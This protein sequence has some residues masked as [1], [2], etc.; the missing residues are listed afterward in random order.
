MQPQCVAKARSIKDETNVVIEYEEFD[1]PE[2]P[3]KWEAKELTYT[4]LK[5]SEDIPGKAQ[6]RIAMNL[7]MTTW[8]FEI[9]LKLTWVP[10]TLGYDISIE[11]K[12]S[13][14]DQLFKERPG[15]LAYAYFPGQ[16]AVS[17]IIVFNEDYRWSLNGEPILA[18][19]EDP[20]H[21]GPSDQ[22]K[23]KTYNLIHVMIHEIGHSLGLRH[24]ARDRSNDDVMYPIYDGENLD[25][26]DWDLVRIR[27]IYGIR[28]WPWGLYGRVKRWLASRKRRY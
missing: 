10:K 27:K 19:D 14:Q 9:P 5:D 11:F 6:E 17:G 24:S 13:L 4:I 21:Y 7:A 25:L 28:V 18:H 23:F 16:G 1:Q 26:S 3:N 2:W 22:T 8:D 15:T 20:V 12:T